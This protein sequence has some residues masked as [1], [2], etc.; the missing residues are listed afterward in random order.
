MSPLRILVVD[1]EIDQAQA[2]RESLEALEFVVV[3][4]AKDAYQAIDMTQQLR[5]DLVLMDTQMHGPSGIEAAALIRDLYDTPVLFLTGHPEE[6][7]NS[8][9]AGAFGH[10]LKP[11]DAETLRTAVKAALYN[12]ETHN[13]RTREYHF[14]LDPFGRFLSLSKPAERFTG[15]S[16]NELVGRSFEELLAPESRAVSKGLMN[17]ALSERQPFQLEVDLVAKDG[18]RIAMEV[19]SRPI[20]LEEKALGVSIIAREKWKIFATEWSERNR[21]RLELI[22]KKYSEGLG[23]TEVR[24]LEDL[25]VEADRHVESLATVDPDRLKELRVIYENLTGEQ[26]HDRGET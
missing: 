12:Y 7:E 11:V 25:Q 8:L 2:N 5:P 23:E 13:F 21:R 19:D 18:Q 14:A 3:G 1:D 9:R 4:M 16:R 22:E 17:R 10:L 26:G 15:Y 20:F 6:R 24:E